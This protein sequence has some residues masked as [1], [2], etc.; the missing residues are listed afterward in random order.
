MTIQK[1]I[2]HYLIWTIIS[3]LG[4]F[5]YTRIILGP[6]PEP[7]TGVMKYFDG[8]YLL[9]MYHVGIVIGC[10]IAILFIL[11]DV[12]YLRKKLKNNPKSVAIR[13]LVIVIITFVL[14]TTHYVCEKVIDI[15]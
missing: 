15:I 12:F 9:V 8:I 11:I 2:L 5:G 7:S 13:F 14:G 10:I 3:F 4:A 1:Q 6:K